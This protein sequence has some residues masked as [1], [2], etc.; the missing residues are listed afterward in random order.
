MVVAAAGITAAGSLAA[1]AIGASKSGGSSSSGS[2]EPWAAQQPYMLDGLKQAQ[3]NLTNAESVPMPTNFVAGQNAQQ[4]GADQVMWNQ[5]MGEG[6]TYLPWQGFGANAASQGQDYLNGIKGIQSNGIGAQSASTDVLSNYAQTGNL[7]G[8]QSWVDPN[9]GAS[10]T[11][12]GMGNVSALGDAHYYANQAATS[13]LNPNGTTDA[14]VAGGT[15]LSQ[16]PGLDSAI[17][18]ANR[19]TNRDLTE[20]TLPQMRAAAMSSGNA[21][22]SREGAMEAIATRGASDR[23]A[24]TAAQMRLGA[25]TQGANLGASGYN[26]G[27][28][29]AVSAGNALNATGTASGALLGTEQGLQQQQNQF[30]VTSQLGAANNAASQD[31]NYQTAN[32]GAQLTANGQLGTAI[33]TG[34]NATNMSQA[35]IASG[36]NMAY[37]GATNDQTGAQAG[38]NND[39]ANYNMQTTGQSDLLNNYWKIAG[40]GMGS[41]S[42]SS[43]TPNNGGVGGALAGALGGAQ[44]GYGLYQNLNK[45]GWFGGDTPSYGT[46]G[47]AADN[48][49]VQ[50]Q[51]ATF[52]KDTG[53]F[54]PLSS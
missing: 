9:L 11:Q 47:T 32:T 24:D 43:T 38:I 34:M 14:A 35:G 44:A 25:Y 45:S 3:T 19:D 6:A 8:Q 48:G 26:T 1:G 53:W 5:G 2:S 40:S 29:T 15:A 22:S 36:I 28:S 46:S 21:N 12:T 51:G 37:Q 33:N 52:F 13:A 50:T 30:G 18:A 23:M 20:N 7:P 4:A 31:L 39:L 16:N 41:S 27:L 49:G 54:N 17:D 42:T 10:M